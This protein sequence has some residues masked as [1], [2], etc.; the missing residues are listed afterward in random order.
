[1]A[2]VKRLPQMIWEE[3]Q[4]K[5]SVSHRN[6]ELRDEVEMKRAVSLLD[7]LSDGLPRSH[8]DSSN[9]FS[10]E[11]AQKGRRFIRDAADLVRC[12]AIKLEVELAFGSTVVPIGKRFEL[13]PSQAPLREC[14]PS[15]ANGHPWCLPGET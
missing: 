5:W 10:K 12:L 7:S 14:G 15:D 13:A 1:M 11:S 2:I 9:P 4:Q 8:K 6:L 3:A